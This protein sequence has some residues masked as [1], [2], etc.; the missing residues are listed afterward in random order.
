MNEFLVYAYCR[1]DGTFYY[2]G[3]GNRRRPYV[4]R[5]TKG[6]NPPGDRSRIIILHSALSEEK[7]FE[8]EKNLILFYGRKDLNTGL[9]KN[10]TDGGEGTSGWEA[11]ESFRLAKKEKASQMHQNNLGPDGKSRIAKKAALSMN[12]KK[13]SEKDEVGRSIAA[14]NNNF[15]KRSKPL[16]VTCIKTGATLDFPNSMDA[17]L[18]LGVSAR[19]LRKVAA[20]EIR[21]H[22]GYTAEFT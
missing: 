13:H 7:A 6:V 3:K 8:Y 9:L 19:S 11:P 22:K 16:R 17:A 10:R 12:K 18:A 21:K 2:I 14:K 1:V 15:G 20:G 5:G 4:N